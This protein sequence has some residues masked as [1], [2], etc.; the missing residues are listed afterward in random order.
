MS[1]LEETF[2]CLRNLLNCANL[3]KWFTNNYLSI[4]YALHM[5]VGS[6]TIQN[7]ILVSSAPWEFQTSWPHVL[8]KC[9]LKDQP[10][11]HLAFMA[12][13]GLLSQ[14]VTAQALKSQTLIWRKGIGFKWILSGRE[15]NGKDSC[16][17]YDHMAKRTL[18]I[19]SLSSSPTSALGLVIL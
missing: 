17:G 12:W 15:A 1:S 18:L 6:E 16:T 7:T 8:L 11:G 5:V 4:N 3:C 2:Q 19:S 9:C 14:P 10:K 13:L